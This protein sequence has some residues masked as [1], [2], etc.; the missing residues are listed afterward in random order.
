MI[1]WVKFDT[2]T[3]K[4]THIERMLNNTKHASR[5]KGFVNVKWA[6]WTDRF[7]TRTP[8]QTLIESFSGET[9]QK[10]REK[11]HPLHTS[12]FIWTR[13]MFPNILLRYIG[14]NVDMVHHVESRTPF[15]DHHLTE[16]ANAIPPS[17]KMKFLPETEDW[18][19]KYVLR[20][21][22]R[23][24]ITEEIYERRK[25]P[26]IGP[27]LFLKGGHMHKM[28][29]RIIT[30]ENVEMLGWADWGMYDGLVE[31]AFDERDQGEMVSLSQ[32]FYP[33]LSPSPM[34]PSALLETGGKGS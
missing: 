10:I 7:A 1:N 32:R 23:P 2:T 11:W 28:L 21:A 9:R 29:D 31:R 33:N 15:L 13:S 18:R 6:P 3:N 14:D 34:S 12:E 25:H 16:Y 22:V 27:G 4:E 17:L 8:E 20:E 30:R 5:V 24:F 19:E 26:F